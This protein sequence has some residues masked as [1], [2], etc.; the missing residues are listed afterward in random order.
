MVVVIN[1]VIP[2]CSM[3]GRERWEAGGRIKTQ[4][5]TLN[6]GDVEVVKFAVVLCSLVLL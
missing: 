2:S 1:I 6:L 5:H 4:M 3:P